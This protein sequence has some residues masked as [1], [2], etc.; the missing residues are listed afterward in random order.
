MTG[1][2]VASVRSSVADYVLALVTVYWIIIIA[3]ILL[4]WIQ[5][6]NARIPYNR[7]TTA[8]IGFIQDAATPY[9]R[10]FR[11]IIP[12]IGGIDLSPIVA[13]IV[14]RFVGVAVAN[15]IRG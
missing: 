5:L 1:L 6:L 7:G 14:L 11:R 3:W 15:A 9:L 13:I 8:V 4:S 2:V 10:I 12:P